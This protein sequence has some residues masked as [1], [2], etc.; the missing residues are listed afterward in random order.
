VEKKNKDTAAPATDPQLSVSASAAALVSRTATPARSQPRR[1]G[2][3]T[4][5]SSTGRSVGP[6][7]PTSSLAG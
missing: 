5:R 6:R 2:D 7:L 4:C 1:R 3:L